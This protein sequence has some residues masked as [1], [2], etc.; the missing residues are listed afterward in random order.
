MDL[1]LYDYSLPKELIAQRAVFPKSSSRL[2]VLEGTNISHKRFHDIV[3]YFREGDVIVVN[4]SKVSR[5]KIFGKKS[6][7]A[8]AEIII[9][10]G[11]GREFFCRIKTRALKVGNIIHVGRLKADVVSKS[12]EGQYVIRFDSD[13]DA[14]IRK[15]AIL[16]APPYVK[17]KVSARE[18]QTVYSKKEGSLAA[19]TAGLHFT[20]DMI[21]KLEKK[22]VKI[23]KVCLH[24]SF[25]TFVE[26]TQKNVKEKKLASES[27]DIP[28][29]SADMINSAK[30]LFVV[31]TTSL[32]AIE[33]AHDG[34]KVVAGKGNSELFIYPGYKFKNRISG[35][36]TNFHL[37]R[38]SLLLLVS[39][40]YGWDRI[41]KAY[42][43]AVKE[44]YRFYS[45]GDGMLML[46]D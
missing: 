9:E 12:D 33:S 22:G 20:G 3:D 28:K 44:K 16:P 6:T 38:S 2:M 36:V 45:L 26:I 19:P 32:K 29:R 24:I 42:E 41:K 23:A 39:A 40:F 17:R 4:E 18:Y 1:S 25:A 8:P 10:S 13:A 14:Y 21:R 27:Y 35:M 15:N 7:G 5:A 30:R 37:P 11:S 31:G 34:K 46:K 43:T